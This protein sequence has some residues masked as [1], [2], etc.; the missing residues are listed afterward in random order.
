MAEQT[1]K[2]F[3]SYRVVES[4]QVFVARVYSHLRKQP[5]ISPFFYADQQG[6]KRAWQE[7]IGKKLGESE[8][9]IFFAG[10]AIGETQ[11]KEALA[12]AELCKHNG[13]NISDRSIVVKLPNAAVLST[14][15]LVEYQG[16]HEVTCQAV[17]A[18][19]AVSTAIAITKS[20]GS[21]WVAL[22]GLP[23]GYPFAYEKDIIDAYVARTHI[24][25]VSVLRD[26]CPE[27]WPE[28]ELIGGEQFQPDPNPIKEE[29][30]GTFRDNKD[31]ILVDGRSKYHKPASMNTKEDCR[32]LVEGKLTFAEA[33]PRSNLCM[34]QQ[35]QNILR[36]G[37]LVSGGIAP[38]INAVIAGIVQRHLLYGRLDQKK[39]RFPLDRCKQYDLQ[40]YGF[41]N[42]FS[43]L[44]AGDTTVLCNALKRTE[45]VEAHMQAIANQGGSA[46]G[47]ARF[48]DMLS[49]GRDPD[50]RDRKLRDIVTS[51]AGNHYDIVYII[52]GDGSM[53]ATHAIWTKVKEMVADRIIPKPISIVG[54]P[55]TM[56]NDVLWVWQTFGF[57]SAVERA[58]EAI[59]QLHTEF[60]SNPRLC[61]VQLF[62][63]DSGFVVSHAALASGVCD[64][65]LIPEVEFS[66]TKLC[67]YINERLKRRLIHGEG[68][69][70]P[71]GMVVM[72]E[73]AI[74]QDIEACLKHLKDE[75]QE[76]EPE[77]ERAIRKFV[78]EGRRVHGQTP[79]ALRTGGLKV[80][81]RMLQDGIR[82]LAGIDQYWQGFR[83]F[84]NEP[85]HLL[86]AIPPSVSDV[87][88]GQRLGVLA[89]DNA[90]AGYTDFM[91]SQW[92][93]EYVLIPLPLVVL[94]RKRVPPNGIFWKSV[95]ASTNQHAELT[96]RIE[97]LGA[98]SG[99]EAA[100]PQQRG[101]AGI[102]ALKE[103]PKLTG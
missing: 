13:T 53:R 19:E 12:F 68:G 2:V 29:V 82:K 66:M 18:H 95:L 17:D 74:P 15:G 33:G 28:P 80:V 31:R 3:L 24:A 34:P 67:D 36:V 77:E 69:Q 51:L 40:I 25:R 62:G 11:K 88:F 72:A 78:E 42:G 27:Q 102:Q 96:E 103:T 7:F 58:R 20:L 73:T 76:L 45:E 10:V 49:V 87:I 81:S 37:I 6:H 71:H 92:M 26:G 48:D 23:V 100:T 39:I 75:K 22:D 79:D 98:G 5:L 35:G 54:I 70:S 91:I 57:L 16:C 93:T 61:I 9:L 38:G 86:R 85:R 65:A 63:S 97:A 4:D 1:I 101:G 99:T 44:L 30:I 8:H 90:L 83:V 52:G 55:K 59:R 64:V 84:T 43:G 60:T 14:V 21:K 89:V 41:R 32:C 56:D 46:I 50:E 47:T 94:G